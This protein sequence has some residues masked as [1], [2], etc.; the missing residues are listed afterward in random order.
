MKR[1]APYVMEL[2]HTSAGY[3]N[4]LLTSLEESANAQPK[5]CLSV[6]ILRQAADLTTLLQHCATTVETVSVGSAS[7]TRG[8]TE[9]KLSP[10][11]TVNVTTSPVTGT[12]VSSAQERTMETVSVETANARVNGTWRGTQRV[13]ARPAATPAS[14]PTENIL[15]SSAPDMESASVGNANVKKLMKDN[16]QENTAKTAQ[17]ALASVRS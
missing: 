8:R 15:A 13:S 12:T 17:P 11:N 16:T 10:E 9:K 4:V 6:E 7:A 5:T 3:V 14:P 1:T 2:E